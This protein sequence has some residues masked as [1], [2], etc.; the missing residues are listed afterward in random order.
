MA[1]DGEA[2]WVAISVVGDD[3]L[4]SSGASGRRLGGVTRRG[5][6]DWEST[7]VTGDAWV[8][9]SE[10]GLLGWTVFG[11]TIELGAIS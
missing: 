8:P 9:C 3:R 6:R 10:L 5:D 1:W 11:G 4:I 7:C 2:D